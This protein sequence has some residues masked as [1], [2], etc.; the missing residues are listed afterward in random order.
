MSESNWNFDHHWHHFRPGEDRRIITNF[1]FEFIMKHIKNIEKK[2]GGVLLYI[3]DSIQYQNMPVVQMKQDFIEKIFIEI[4]IQCLNTTKNVFI[5]LIYI[6]PDSDT[7]F[8][9]RTLIDNI[10]S[11]NLEYNQKQERGLY[12]LIYQITSK[13][14]I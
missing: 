4:E 8:S 11:N 14:A 6:V 9:I 12:M 1:P 7:F 3:R 13:C 5:G 2:A 10:F